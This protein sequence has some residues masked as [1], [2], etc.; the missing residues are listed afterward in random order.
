MRDTSAKPRSDIV[1]M[2]MRHSVRRSAGGHPPREPG[3]TINSTPRIMEPREPARYAHAPSRM[4][5]LVTNRRSVHSPGRNEWF[6]DPLQP[7]RGKELFLR[8]LG[9]EVTLARRRRSPSRE[10][11]PAL[12]RRQATARRSSHG[13]HQPLPVVQ[14]TLATWSS[15]VATG[16]RHGPRSR[17][18]S[19]K[20]MRWY[21][22]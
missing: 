17:R 2:S 3:P 4:A 18:D 19:R 15:S 20:R 7:Y 8:N 6:A 9:R 11:R 5:S 10:C 13:K 12:W 21:R 16:A 1:P 22:C 14:S